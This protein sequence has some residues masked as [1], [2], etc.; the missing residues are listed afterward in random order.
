VKKVVPPSAGEFEE[1]RR[2]TYQASV[3]GAALGALVAFVAW[4]NSGTP[5]W[6]L[7]I[8]AG[9]VLGRAA[10]QLRPNIVHWRS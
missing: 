4:V 9:W 5:E 2:R 10:M 6:F 3:V 8:P 1:A 7:A